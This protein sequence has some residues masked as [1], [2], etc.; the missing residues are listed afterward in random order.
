VIN[1]YIYDK[2]AAKKNN[3]FLKDIKND[4]GIYLY[5]D[6]TRGKGDDVNSTLILR[7]SENEILY[8][9]NFVNAGMNEILDAVTS[10]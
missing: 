7:N 3:H 9:V 10:L 8:K 6:Q 5:L 2:R 1:P 4:K